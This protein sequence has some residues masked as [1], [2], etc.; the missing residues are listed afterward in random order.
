MLRKE[1][2][3]SLRETYKVP[4]GEEQDVHYAVERVTYDSATGSK[5]SHYDIIKTN[6]IMFDTVK[7]NLELQGYT[8][9]I[10]YHP[11]GKYSN[12]VIPG[13]ARVEL[14]EKDEEI[15]ALRAEIAKMKAESAPE[16]SEA[17]EEKPTEN[18][19]AKAESAPVKKGGRA[20]KS[21]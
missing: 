7:R 19:E 14:A 4:K 21:E 1:N 5:T 16:K 15:A 8:V 9:E 12:V 18:V 3:K 17:N 20:K 10:L 2:L 13:D 6:V 11:D